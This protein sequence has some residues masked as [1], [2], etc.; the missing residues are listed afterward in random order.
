MP[1]CI[2]PRVNLQLSRLAYTVKNLSLLCVCVKF[3]LL[4][5]TVALTLVE[6]RYILS[7]RHFFQHRVPLS[8]YIFLKKR[9]I[10]FI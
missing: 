4:T 3:E 8:N 1:S 10:L 5:I 7:L 6:S 9:L 2:A